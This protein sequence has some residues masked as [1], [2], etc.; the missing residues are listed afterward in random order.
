[1]SGHRARIH[2]RPYRCAFTCFTSDSIKI[3]ILYL[4]DLMY[5]NRILSYFLSYNDLLNTC[6]FHACSADRARTAQVDTDRTDR[7]KRRAI[8]TF[9]FQI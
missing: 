9:L 5:N 4:N 8:E 3:Y 7:T 6:G 2:C 1:M